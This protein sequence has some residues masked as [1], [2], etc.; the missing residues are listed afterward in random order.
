[1]LQTPPFDLILDPACLL[2]RSTCESV[3][4]PHIRTAVHTHPN[5]AGH[6]M[7]DQYR[8]EP[9]QQQAAA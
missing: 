2:V 7:R 5:T 1:M 8:K 3:A 9:D 6:R 4:L